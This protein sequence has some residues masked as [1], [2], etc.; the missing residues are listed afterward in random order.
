MAAVEA[1]KIIQTEEAARLVGPVLTVLIGSHM[2]EV[3]VA[4]ATSVVAGVE[5]TT[6]TGHTIQDP[7][8]TIKDLPTVIWVITIT[9]VHHHLFHRR[10]SIKM[11]MV[12]HHPHL[13][14]CPM[15]PFQTTREAMSRITPATKVRYKTELVQV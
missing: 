5:T 2:T 7:L 12:H 6:A 15:L 10:L 13:L 1:T 4:E 11:A 9:P 14:L 8:L 3:V